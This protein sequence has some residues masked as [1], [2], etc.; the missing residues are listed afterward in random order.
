MKRRYFCQVIFLILL[1]LILSLCACK[2]KALEYNVVFNG[3]GGILI[4]GE[5]EQTVKDGF[6]A[7][8]PKYEKEGYTF[9]GWD[10]EFDSVEKDMIIIAQWEKNTY[11]V[12]FDGGS[13][14]LISGESEQ[15]VEHGKSAVAPVYAR[16]G[17][18]LLWDKSFHIID[19]DI[20][21][22]AVWTK[23]IYKVVFHGAGGALK[24][25]EFSQ[26]VEHGLSVTPPEYIREGYTFIGWD[27]SLNNI[28]EETVITAKWEINEYKVTFN[29]N[30][31]TLISGE[32]TQTIE[33]GSF[34]LA[35]EYEKE[36]FQ[37]I[38]DTPFD[39]IREDITVTAV[40]I[41]KGSD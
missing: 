25:G 6:A 40:W 15:T 29:G 10:E 28:K 4:E 17:Y 37:L 16:E 7:I 8:A 30:G 1:M 41:I 14:Q 5:K 22:T 26:E 38:W 31:G 2:K 33:Y 35:P 20:T 13:G 9:I 34:A 3:G 18:H 11:K 19:T 39:F 21:I 32:E 23:N 12:V 27:K 24:S 36:G